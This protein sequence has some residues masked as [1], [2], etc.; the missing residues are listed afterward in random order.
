MRPRMTITKV[1]T[2]NMPRKPKSSALTPSS[3]NQSVTVRKISNGYIVTKADFGKSG[4]KETQTYT[5]T[6]PDLD[7][8][9]AGMKKNGRIK[10]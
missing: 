2:T 4:Y 6:A 10:A 3:E 1:T 8:I 7:M 5:P 9:A